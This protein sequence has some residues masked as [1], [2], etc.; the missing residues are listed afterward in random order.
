MLFK[1]F[2]LGLIWRIGLII[3]LSAGL[4]YCLVQLFQQKDTTI[5]WLSGLLLFSL[6]GYR[7]FDL[8][9]YSNS[10]NRKLIRFFDAIQYDDFSIKFSSDNTYGK[11]F[12]GLNQQF[13]KVLES[14]RK[15]RAENE[16]SLHLVNTIIQNVQTGLL[17][18]DQYGRIELSN[19]AACRL[20]GFYRL[21][22]I[23][24]LKSNHQ[25][26]AEK[27][28]VTADK[29]FL[30]ES[31]SGL[32]VAINIVAIRLGGQIKNL[33]SLQNIQPELQQKEV[34]AWQNLTRVLRH[35]IMNSLTPILSLIGTMKHIVDKELPASAN[36]NGAKGDLQE[37]LQTLESRGIGMINFVDGY[38][39]FTSIPLPSF[40]EVAIEQLLQRMMNLLQPEMAAVNI[41]F[42]I[43][44]DAAHHLINADAEQLSMV[45]INLIKNAK[46]ALSYTTNASI[47]IKSYAQ[48]QSVFIEVMD[49]GPGIEP[50]ALEDIFIPF[51]TTK[52]NGS[53]IGLSLSR[54]I[55]QQH[56]G[57][58]KV[59]SASGKGCRFV[60]QLKA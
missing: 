46:E 13:N 60:V 48:N 6:I 7:G 15:I 28:L 5:F 26:L 32:Q 14:F 19:S 11:S 52:E 25:E 42:T 45:F 41:A 51:F 8:F 49:N 17:L 58:I 10:T 35:E 39:S 21:K 47:H 43:K 29:H 4:V 36:D 2:S 22:N 54:Q 40:T 50:E 1:R 12:Q 53:G 16:A 9:H 23:S 57:T 59:F 55:I 31:A 20:L 34:E 24:E 56:G 37:A 44:N 18:Y 33:V 38:R 3:F 30:Y 27:L